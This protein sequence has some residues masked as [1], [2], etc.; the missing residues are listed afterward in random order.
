MVA[1]IT[2]KQA[3]DYQIPELGIRNETEP[4]GKWGRIRRTYLQENRPMLYS[5]LVLSEKLFPHLLEIQQSA[6][7][8]MEQ[9][10]QALLLK[11]PAPDKKTDQ[12]GWVQHMNSLRAQAEEIITAEL[13]NS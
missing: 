2:Y 5:D 10:M 12:M 9:M 11:N 6:E 13:I 3:G 4:L 8:R 1:E 7:R